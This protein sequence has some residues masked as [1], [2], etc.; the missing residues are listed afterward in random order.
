MGG[1]ALGIRPGMIR[2][3]FRHAAVYSVATMAGRIIGFVMLPF[4]ANILRDV[5]YGVIGMIDA[6]LF[7][8]TSL[9]GYNLHGAITRIYH[10]EPDPAAKPTVVSTGTWLAGLVVLALALV[11]AVFSKPASTLLLGTPEH[12][13][14]ICM[15]LVTFVCGMVMQSAMSILIITRRSAIFSMISIVKLVISLS[16]NIYLIVILRLGLFGYFL[17]GM[18]SALIGLAISLVVLKHYCG[19]RWDRGFAR[20]L[21]QYQYPL[22]PGSLTRFGARQAE[23]VIVRY[24]IDLATV[25]VLEMAYKFPVLINMLVINPFNKSWG[26][27]ALEIADEPGA[28]RHIANMFVY[29]FFISTAAFLALAVNIETVLK[30]LTPPEFWPAA[31]VAQID[32]AQVVMSGAALYLGFG[33]YYAKKTGV[34]ARITIVTSVFKLGLSFVLI[35]IWGLYGAA[36]SGLLTALAMAVAQWIHSQRY[37]R[38]PIDWG[39]IVLIAV[40]A[41]GLMIGIGQIDV[42]SVAA[43]GEPVLGWV[44]GELE[45]LRGTWLGDLKEG[46]VIRL[47]QERTDLVLDLAVRTALVGTFF[48]LL[49]VV[50]V[51]TQR[52]VLALAKRVRGAG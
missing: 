46:K 42:A 7:L 12:W 24:Q 50:H 4:Y 36:W 5:G 18:I 52:K 14:L 40:C 22:I 20:S 23:R 25:G 27:K 38:L 2:D 10:E 43:W 37:Y 32:A 3:T 47:V 16:L 11:G 29:F 39:K 26:T 8:L 48:L 49:P 34:L 31:R 15:A 13:D 33:L 44:Q 35:G 1:K 41:G 45:G 30:L 28:P 17:A 6:S 19:F 9:I 51:E 21:Y